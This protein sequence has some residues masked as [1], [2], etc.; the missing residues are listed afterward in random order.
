VVL[1]AV[2][3]WG[4]YNIFDEDEKKVVEVAKKVEPAATSTT[5][6]SSSAIPSKIIEIDFSEYS[7]KNWG[8]DPFFRG[9][10]RVESN[11]EVEQPDIDWLLGGILYSDN[12]PAAVINKKV[13]HQGDMINGAKVVEINREAVILQ[14][15]GTNFVLGIKKAKS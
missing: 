8:S 4:Y 15:D 2:S 11:G 9:R 14:K 7:S 5:A 13:V 3:I 6:T 1:F 12:N 10:I